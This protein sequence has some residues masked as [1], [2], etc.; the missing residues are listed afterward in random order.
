MKLGFGILTLA[1]SLLSTEAFAKESIT[2]RIRA[3]KGSSELLQVVMPRPEMEGKD[4]AFQYTYAGVEMNIVYAFGQPYRLLI[5]D[6]KSGV[7]AYTNL[8][9]GKNVVT[10]Q[11]P[12]RPQIQAS[13]EL[14]ELGSR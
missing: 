4:D 9:S 13:C 5:N 12:N 6:T 11:V 3:E 10:L 7:Y 8:R 2:C 14:V 1:V